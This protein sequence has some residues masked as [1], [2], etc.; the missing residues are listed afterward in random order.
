MTAVDSVPFSAMLEENLASASPDVLRA[1]LALFASQMMGAEADALC[2]AEY[3]QV[4]DGRTNSRN[5]YRHRAWDTRAGTVDLAIPKLRA[6]SYF[7]EWLLERRSRAEQA[8]VSVVATCYLLGVST[9]RVEKLAQSLG[10]TQLSK[11]Q[12]S[13]MAKTLDERVAQFRNR[14]LDGSPYTFVWIDAL[15]QKVREGG[16]VVNVACLVAVGV[17]ADGHREILGVDVAT[18]ENGSGWVAF[19]RS[20]VA[21]GL[22]G[23]QLVVSDAHGGLVDAIGAVLPGT[24]WQR[25]RTHYARNLMNQV[26]K[27]AAPW[28]AT[29]L[30]TVFEQ[31][32]EQAVRSQMASVIAALDEKFPKAAE[33][34]EA[35]REDLLAFAAYP[36]EAW[37]QIWSNNPQERLNK[38]I[39]RRTDV[40][41]IFPDRDAILR[42]VGAV[43][44]EQS[45][46]WTEQRRYMG[47]EVLERCRRVGAHTNEGNQGT[48]LTLTPLTA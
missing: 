29:L 33:H 28:V 16:R 15:M 6:G 36:R 44:A 35:A 9:R 1:M 2:G 34:L 17:N 14:P 10:V 46:E 24:T 30:R 19:L 27:T 41:G 21:R 13:E 48:E 18:T 22:S 12:V 8:L 31:P 47:T 37:R 39:R 43:L 42:L 5:G 20:L 45:D 40:V 11:S 7:P 25:C 4:S 38:E 26:P 32:D 3:G 23:V